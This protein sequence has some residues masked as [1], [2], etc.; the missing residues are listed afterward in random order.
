VTRAI[1]TKHLQTL[2]ALR[3][4]HL[5]LSQKAAQQIILRFRLQTY[6]AKALQID[7]RTLMRIPSPSFSSSEAAVIAGDYNVVQLKDTI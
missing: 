1:V 2:K 3:H 7:H 5:S 6:L 4:G